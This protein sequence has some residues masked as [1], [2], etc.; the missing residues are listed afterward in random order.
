MRMEPSRA[1]AR[2]ERTRR[3]ISRAPM[4]NPPASARTTLAEPHNLQR[5]WLPRWH[6]ACASRGRTMLRTTTLLIVTILAGGPVGSLGCEL[7]CASPAAE[8]HHRSVGCHDA[9]AFTPFVTEARRTESAPVSATPVAL[10]DSVS[11]GPAIDETT[12]GWCL[13]NVQPPRPP[14]SRDVLRV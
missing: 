13:F 5:F 10:V 9:A 14:S 11:I 2:H 1:A 6:F 12:A 7:W 8:D 4:G 3:G